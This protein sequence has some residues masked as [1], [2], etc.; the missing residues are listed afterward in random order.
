MKYFPITKSFLAADALARRLEDEYALA[1]V[2]CQLITT[3]VRDV[4][5]VTTSKQ[6]FVFF[7]YRSGHRTYE[8]IAVEWSFVA[9]LDAH[10]VPV[11]PAM[12]TTNGDLIEAWS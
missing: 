8:E 7:V 4:Y 3:T 6:R 2:R 9:Y 5:L 1:D 12:P 11:A 10:G